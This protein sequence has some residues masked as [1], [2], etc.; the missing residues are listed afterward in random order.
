[1]AAY[2]PNTTPPQ[3]QIGYQYLGG[4]T[5]W[6]NQLGTFR[7]LSPVKLASA[8]PGWALAAED[9]MFNGSTWSRVHR[10]PGTDHPD[11][12][13]H[14][15]ADGSVDWVRMEDLYQITTYDTAGHRWYF[16]QTDLSVFAPNQRLMLQFRP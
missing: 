7:S 3:W 8:K 14:L 12:G 16:H 13:N 11:G 1:L 15:R 10:R 5:A 4:V 6:Y 2:N 9:I